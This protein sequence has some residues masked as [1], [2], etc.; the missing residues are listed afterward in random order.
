V[1]QI[2]KPKDSPKKRYSKSTDMC[3]YEKTFTAANFDNL[4]T[5]CKN[6]ILPFKIVLHTIL[7]N[8]VGIS[9]L[10]NEYLVFAQIQSSISLLKS[11][12]Q[13]SFFLKLNY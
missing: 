11:I 4:P 8:R 3:S 10:L 6:P 7:Q 2:S 1:Y 12:V 9:F 13:C 5:G